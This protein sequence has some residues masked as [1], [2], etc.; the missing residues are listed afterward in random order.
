MGMQEMQSKPQDGTIRDM[1]QQAQ[2]YQ[3]VLK[4]FNQ[5][6]E[7][8]LIL[9]LEMSDETKKRVKPFAIASDAY[10]PRPPLCSKAGTE[11]RIKM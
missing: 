1:T 11:F 6:L 4:D 8:D 7:Q 9:Y 5:N 2:C 10:L 3:E